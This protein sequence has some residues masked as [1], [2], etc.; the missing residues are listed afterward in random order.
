MVTRFLGRPEQVE[1]TLRNHHLKGVTEVEDTA[2]IYL[3]NGDKTA[4]IYASTAYTQ[5]AP[6]LIE[7]HTEKAVL[8]L[9]DDRREIREDGNT[10]FMDFAGAERMGRSYWGAGHKA[11]IRDFYRSIREARPYRNDAASCEDTVQTMLTI[12]EQNP[13]A[14]G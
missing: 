3:K 9:G 11:C 10:H 6:V 7:L 5:D 12:Y 13:K 1:S 14:L 8:R 4:L 2:E